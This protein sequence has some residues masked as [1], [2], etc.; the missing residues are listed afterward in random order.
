MPARSDHDRAPVRALFIGGM[1]RSGTTILERTLDL[2][3]DVTGLGEVVHLWERSLLKDELCG[4]GLPFSQ[5]PFWVEVGDRAFGGWSRVDPLRVRAL[6]AR[7]DRAS[8]APRLALRLGGTRWRAELDEY[9]SYYARLY[10][11]AAEVA[12][13][14]V[15]VDS[16]K[17][18]SLPWV[19]MHQPDVDLRVVHCVRDARAVAYS[20]T[21]TVA[22]P[23]AR[24]SSDAEMQ[25]YTPARLSSSWTLHNLVVE[26]LRARRVPIRR[27]RYEDWV[28]DPRAA[29]EELWRFA[30]LTPGPAGTGLGESWVDLGVT[31]TCSGNPSRFATG[32]VELRPDE[33]WRRELPVPSHR[34]VTALTGPLLVGYGYLGGAR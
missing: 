18:A 13:T 8:R 32:R 22:R 5:C 15:V 34:L 31:H 16:S 29:T 3:P 14:T 10:R 12:G 4:C 24:T 28:Q 11:A 19:L 7:I 33:R 21:R 23:E 6:Q 20:W 25:R 17:Q 2:H 26:G 1:G 27:L 30:G 9:G